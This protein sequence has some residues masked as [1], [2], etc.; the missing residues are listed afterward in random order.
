MVDLVHEHDALFHSDCVGS[1]GR[2]PLDVFQLGFDAA[3]FSGHK[4]GTAK[5]IGVLYLR[6]KTPFKPL[7]FGSGQENGMRGGTQ[8]V[9]LA[10]Q[11]QKALN[12]CNKHIN[13]DKQHFL[14]LKHQLADGISDMDNLRPTVDLYDTEN[15]LPN[16]V[17]LLY[18]NISSETLILHYGK[19][20][21][22]VSG[23][24]ACS[25]NDKEPSH[26]L[27]ALKIPNN[28]IDGALRISF[29][30]TNTKNDICKF[31]EATKALL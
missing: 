4:I 16:I 11:L 13:E 25:S 3:S 17:H 6:S 9:A 22:Q 28:E 8:N 15:Y 24:P 2:I 27:K 21:I 31:L 7:I 14:E 29:S 12:F 30:R 19:H 23:G 5:G 20:K 26:V 1:F 10:L 18:K